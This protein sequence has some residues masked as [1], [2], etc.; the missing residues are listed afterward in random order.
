MYKIIYQALPLCQRHHYK[1]G[2]MHVFI[3]TAT[4]YGTCGTWKFE[5]FTSFHQSDKV[6]MSSLTVRLL[7][8]SHCCSNLH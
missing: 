6:V 8:L 3:Q 5:S 4:H 7:S 2:M 1:A